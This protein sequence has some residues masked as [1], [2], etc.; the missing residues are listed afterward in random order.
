VVWVYLTFAIA[1]EV[2]GT[3]LLPRTEGFRRLWPTLATMA[4]YAGAIYLLSLV[5]KTLGV[6]VMYALWSGL[7]VAA[8]AAIGMLFLGERASATKIIGIVLVIAGVVVLNL[9]GVH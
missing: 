1:L 5:L 4:L 6:G 3:S 7:G 9:G 2:A 8:V